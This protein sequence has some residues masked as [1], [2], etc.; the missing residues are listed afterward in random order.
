VT[1]E[2]ELIEL[3]RR[4]WEAL[5]TGPGRATDFYRDLLTEDAVMLFP[6]GL[7]LHGRA[8]ILATMDAPPWESHALT[9]VAVTRPAEDVGVVSYVV[10][11]VRAAKPYAALVSS[12]YVRRDGSWRLYFHQHTLKE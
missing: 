1:G 6:G 4:G 7:R 5:A 12:H 11:A 2:Q 9:D 8:A 3:E 10:G